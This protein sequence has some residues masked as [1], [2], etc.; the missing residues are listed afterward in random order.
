MSGPECTDIDV[1][2]V[3]AGLSG[4]ATAFQLQ[5]RGMAVEVLEAGG[6]AGGRHRHAAS[7]RRL[8]REGPE[9]RA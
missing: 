9:Q 8:V 5:R 1:V 4:L 2:V 7:R 6:R 3:G